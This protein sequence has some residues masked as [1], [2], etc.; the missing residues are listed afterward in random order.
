MITKTGD[1]PTL[2]DV[3]GT[4]PGRAVLMSIKVV[5]TLD[6]D[7]E[8]MHTDLV[9]TEGQPDPWTWA[10]G[11][12]RSMEDDWPVHEWAIVGNWR[13]RYLRWKVMMPIPGEHS[14]EEYVALWEKERS[15]D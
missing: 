4:V 10:L 1:K 14:P 15:R 5:D 6:E 7:P 12:M 9:E 2:A 8:Q 11:L 3:D 13:A